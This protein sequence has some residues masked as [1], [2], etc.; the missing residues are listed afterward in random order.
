M[1]R[2]GIAA[3]NLLWP[4][5]GLLRVQRTKAAMRL[6]AMPFVL[7]LASLAAYELLPVFTFASWA[8]F[9]LISLGLA[10]AIYATAITL[11]WRASRLRMTELPWWSRWYGLVAIWIGLMAAYWPVPDIYQSYSRTFYMPAESMEPVLLVNDRFVA[12]MRPPWDLGRG[13][14]VLVEAPRG[15]IYIKRVAAI[16]GDRIAMRDGVVVLNGRPVAQRLVRVERRQGFS[17]EPVNGRRLKEQ[18]PGEAHPHEIYDLDH[19]IFDDMAEQVVADGHLF[20]LGDNRDQS[21]DSRVPIAEMGLEQVP[22]SAVRGEALFYFWGRD[23]SR[24]GE[25]LNR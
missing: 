24:I 11:S 1:A 5:L 21:A 22:R 3:L 13:S 14:L 6:I 8:A 16:A 4:G 18:F 10:L 12:R 15:G 19:T 7:I 2:I 23:R 20:L 17:G 25:P 9:S